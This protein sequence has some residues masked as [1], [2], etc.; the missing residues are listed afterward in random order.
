LALR[1]R[2]R[3]LAVVEAI[4]RGVN[5]GTAIAIGVAANLI[6]IIGLVA[7][8]NG[9]V[10]WTADGLGFGVVTLDRIFGYVFTPLAILMGVDSNDYVT[11]GCLLGQ[12]TL[13]N[14]FVAVRARTHTPSANQAAVVTATSAVAEACDLCVRVRACA[15]ACGA[16]FQSVNTIQN[17][18][19]AEFEPMTERSLNIVTYAL[20]GFSNIGSVGMTMS[21]MTAIAPGQTRAPHHTSRSSPPPHA[22]C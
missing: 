2:P 11:V 18:F 3:C 12:K 10:G 14:E 19:S 8:L 6:A 21:A 15:C 9:V 4:S 7:F 17:G 22:P 20:C 16:Q 5:D 1:L 13:L